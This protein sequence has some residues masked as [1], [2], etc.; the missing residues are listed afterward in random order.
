L[1]EALDGFSATV[2]VLRD[3]MLDKK[4][5]YEE[6]MGLLE[7]LERAVAC[8]RFGEEGEKSG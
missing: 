7:H 4:E 6:K 1:L 2:D 3:E 5:I 8:M